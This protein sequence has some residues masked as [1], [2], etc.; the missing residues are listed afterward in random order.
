M[1]RCDRWDKRNARGP[2]YPHPRPEDLREF[3]KLGSGP[4]EDDGCAF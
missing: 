2:K 3:H 1:L 4:V